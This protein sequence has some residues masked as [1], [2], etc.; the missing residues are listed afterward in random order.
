MTTRH[1]ALRLSP[2]PAAR[3]EHSS[4]RVC[5]RPSQPRFRRAHRQARRLATCGL[6]C[7][8]HDV[9]VGTKCSTLVGRSTSTQM[10]SK[11]SAV[12]GSI[13]MR[14]MLTESQR[15]AG[16]GTAGGLATA[17]EHPFGA[18][19]V[20]EYGPHCNV[21]RTADGYDATH[22]VVDRPTKMAH[23]VPTATT[24]T[25]TKRPHACWTSGA[26]AD[27]RRKRC[28]RG[29]RP[30]RAARASQPRTRLERRR[31]ARL[32]ARPPRHAARSARAPVAPWGRC[33]QAGCARRGW[34]SGAPSGRR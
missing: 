34:G 12:C 30:G 26:G 5:G 16:M 33:S 18:L 7:C 29:R 28:A 15:S 4:T 11:R 2:E 13:T 19:G 31:P 1:A 27:R 32:A 20:S 3:V 22:V 24:C 25:A 6:A 9:A 21:P 23:F 14:F 17:A 8:V 10:G